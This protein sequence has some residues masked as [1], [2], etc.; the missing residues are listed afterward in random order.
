[1]SSSRVQFYD[2][3]EAIPMATL[4]RCTGQSEARKPL[5]LAGLVPSVLWP[6][7]SD[8]EPCGHG[9]QVHFKWV[10]RYR[11]SH[12]LITLGRL[13]GCLLWPPVMEADRCPGIFSTSAVGRN[14]VTPGGAGITQQD[15]HALNIVKLTELKTKFSLVF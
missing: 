9:D 11:G 2:G 1:M 3:V 14:R 13:L 6:F 8:P 12:W 7:V 10:G 5:L 4:P 15:C